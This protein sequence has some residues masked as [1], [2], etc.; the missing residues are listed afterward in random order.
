MTKT[1]LLPFPTEIVRAEAKLD[2]AHNKWLREYE[3]EL[4]NKPKDITV[5]IRGSSHGV[6]SSNFNTH[7]YNESDGYVDIYPSMY[8]QMLSLE[9]MYNLEEIPNIDGFVTGDY[10][11][12]DE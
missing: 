9:E 8:S 10:D 2:R 5:T 11:L 4:A 12:F 1:N 3:K 6:T 7:V